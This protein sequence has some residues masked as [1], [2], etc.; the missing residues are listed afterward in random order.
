MRQHSS[1]VRPSL[2]VVSD[3]G[4]S[5]A[6]ACVREAWPAWSTTPG[7]TEKDLTKLMTQR[8]RVRARA[9]LVDVRDHLGLF[10][11]VDV[12]REAGVPAVLL[13]EA[14]SLDK[15]RRACPGAIALPLSAR[16]SD[17]A[18]ALHAV[19]ERQAAFD[20]VQRELDVSRRF[21]GGLRGEMDKLHEELQLA[22]SVQQELLPTTLPECACADFGVLFNPAGYVSGDIYDV[23]RLDDHTIGFFLADAVGHGVPAA[24]M[25]M[26][27]AR[28]MQLRAPTLDG[29]ELRTPGEALEILN[30]ELVRR[31]MRCPRFATAVVGTIDERTRE[32][33]LAGAGHPPALLYSVEGTIERIDSSGGLLGVFEEDTF[34]DATFTLKEDQTLVLYSDGFETAFPDVEDPHDRKLVTRTYEDRFEQLA[35]LRDEEGL[36]PAIDALRYELNGASGSLHQID[37]ITA[38]VLSTKADARSGAIDPGARAA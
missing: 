21:Q 25:T 14:E 37:D 34:D 9:V 27:I 15:T 17:I 26:V 13:V 22:A 16:P 5:E 19:M 33:T 38:I 10:Q 35:R 7:A 8:E 3:A 1:N 12:V 11:A 36:A 29:W 30:R 31:H 6:W 24:L 4:S 23:Q 2:L 20:S 18:I 32:V 28:G